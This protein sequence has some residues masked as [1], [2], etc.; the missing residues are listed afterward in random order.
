MEESIRKIEGID[1]VS[2]SFMTSRMVIE[3]PDITASL[4]NEVRKRIKKVNPD[5]TF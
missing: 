5:T 4:L 1:S 3:G 2:I